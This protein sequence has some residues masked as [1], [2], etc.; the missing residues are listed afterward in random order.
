MDVLFKF[1]FPGILFCL[2]WFLAFGSVAWA[3]R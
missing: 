3:N 2:R 1:I